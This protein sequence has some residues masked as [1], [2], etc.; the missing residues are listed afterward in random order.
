MDGNKDEA[1]HCIGIAKRYIDEGNG[2]KAKKFL[3]KA[4]RLFPSDIAKGTPETIVETQIT[5]RLF[6]LVL[7]EKISKMPPPKE[8]TEPQPRF[9]RTAPTKVEEPT[10]PEYTNE[11]SEAVKRIKRC[12]DYYEI[13]GL[14]KEA[15][16][17]EI[18]KAYKRLAL[19][20]HPD[21]NK[22]PGSAEAFKALG[23]SEV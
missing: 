13:L 21:K 23:K 11:Q 4:E 16:D 22:C 15:T 14:K 9:R 17:S 8:E 6:V 1:E 2:E 20:V 10:A 19:E 12:K 18:K 5:S 7:L 3:Q